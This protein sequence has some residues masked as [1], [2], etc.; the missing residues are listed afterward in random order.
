MEHIYKGMCNKFYVSVYVCTS[1][2]ACVVP[3]I[4]L[5]SQMLR[6]GTGTITNNDTM[7]RVKNMSLARSCSWWITPWEWLAATASRTHHTRIH[8]QSYNHTDLDCSIRGSIFIHPPLLMNHK[9]FLINWGWFSNTWLSHIAVP[10]PVFLKSALNTRTWRESW[11]RS[12][13]S[14]PTR[15]GLSLKGLMTTTRQY[16]SGFFRGATIPMTSWD[17]VLRVGH[18][19]LH[20]NCD[21]EIYPISLGSSMMRHSNLVFALIHH[22]HPQKKILSC[23]ILIA[24]S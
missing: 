10:V 12:A 13:S 16:K 23:W 20:W 9:L 18:Q 6:Q 7:V 24:K 15:A 14:R 4:C 3:E 1:I 5:A 8:L 21:K 11:H 19:W 2:C 22:P 17:H